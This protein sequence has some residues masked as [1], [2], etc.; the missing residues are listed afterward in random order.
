MEGCLYHTARI[1]RANG[2]VFWTL[3]LSTDISGLYE[4]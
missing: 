1:I 2:D 3:R 4:L